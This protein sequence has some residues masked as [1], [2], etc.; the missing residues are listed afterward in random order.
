MTY[1]LDTNIIIDYLSGDPT[2]MIQFRNVAKNKIPMVIPSVVDYE[3]VRGFCHT[4]NVGKEATYR[5]MRLNCRT[6]EVNAD[7]WKCAASIWATLRKTGYTVGDA[8]ILIAASCIVNGYTLV[9]HNAKD[10]E[11]ITGLPFVDWT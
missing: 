3:V 1:A 4:K 2:V 5:K 8:D 10:F 9:T 11:N 7:I 6:V